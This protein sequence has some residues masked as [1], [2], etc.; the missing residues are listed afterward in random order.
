M[1]TECFSSGPLEWLEQRLRCWFNQELLA[2]Q[3]G[4]RFL[5]STS[6]SFLLQPVGDHIHV[7]I[8]Q[9]VSQE[10]K[11]VITNYCWV[12]CKGRPIKTDH[13]TVIG[14]PALISHKLLLGCLKREA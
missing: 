9:L 3:A 10:F 8:Q 12:A 2:V 1:I 7:Q 11:P 14:L 4:Q 5:I 6:Y 13:K